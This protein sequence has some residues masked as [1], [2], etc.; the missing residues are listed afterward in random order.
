MMY[1]VLSFQ[2]VDDE[3]GKSF[4]SGSNC[5]QASQMCCN[6]D[7]KP[8]NITANAKNLPQKSQCD[9]ICTVIRYFR[10]SLCKGSV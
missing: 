10:S 7:K 2:F 8:P 1:P 3:P 4:G 5:P 6:K 9:L